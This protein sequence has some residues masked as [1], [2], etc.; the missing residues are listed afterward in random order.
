MKDYKV[1]ALFRFDDVVEKVTRNIGDEFYCDE[2]R[3]KFLEKHNAVE[4]VE[5][6][7]IE[8]ENGFL[9]EEPDAGQENK[10]AVKPKKPKKRK[11]VDE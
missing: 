5:K 10:D 3:Y 9:Q 6:A 2:E 4:L 8:E 1:K 11:K 7:K